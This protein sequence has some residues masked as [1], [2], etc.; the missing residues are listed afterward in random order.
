MNVSS[1]LYLCLIVGTTVTAADWPMWRADAGRTASTTQAVPA[2]LAIL[3]SR[4]LGPLTPAYRETR[5]Q[6]DRS[7][8]PVVAGHT[9][10]VGSSRDDSVTAFDTETGS[11]LWKTFTDGPIRFAPVIVDDRVIFGSDD[12]IVRCVSLSTGKQIWDR[13]AVPSNRHVLGNG[14]LISVW[15]VRGGPVAKGGRVYL[16]AGVWPLEG[17]FVYCLDAR[18][19]D[20]IW[21]NDRTGYIY[22]VHPHQAEAFGGVAPQGYLLI[23]GE[24]LVVPSSSAYPARFDLATGT[25]KEFELPSAGRLPGG[26]FASTPDAKQAQKL[27]RRGLLFDDAVNNTRHEDKPRKEGLPDIRTS[28]HTAERDLAFAGPWPDISGT[29][30]SVVVAAEK[31]FVVTEEGR[32]YALAPKSAVTQTPKT[33]NRP[34]PRAAA[35]DHDIASLIKTAGTDRG[36]ALIIGSGPE[37]FIES[38]ADQTH[39][40]I[41]TL[42]PDSTA[43]TQYRQR[44]I[45]IGLYGDRISAFTLES[46]IHGL[47]PYFAN[48]ILIAPGTETPDKATLASLY[49]CLRP[50][51]GKIIGPEALLTAAKDAAL[52]QVELT[53]DSAKHTIIT[54]TGALTGSTNYTGDWSASDDLLVKSPVGILWFDDS[55]GNF[56]RAPQPQFIDGVMVTQNKDWMDASTRKGPVDYR[57]LAPVFS[58]VYTG[59]VL[60]EYEA[61][62]LRDQFADADLKTIQPNQYRPPHQKDDWK[63][64][65]PNPGTRINPMTL[66]T[67]PRVFPKS[68]G[69]DGGFD[70]GSIYTMRSGTAAF[71]DKRVESGTIHISGPRSGCTNSIVPA[72]G[73]LN[74]PYFFEGCTCSYPLP[75]AV[76]LVSLPETFEQW[77]AWGETPASSLSGKIQRLG[78]NFG[79]P[80]DRKTEDGTLWLD[81]P[82][83]GG[84]S[85]EIDVQ[86]DPPDAKTYYHHSV[87]IEG[88]EGWPWVA[89]SGIEGASTIKVSGLKQGSYTVRLHFAEPKASATRAL[90]LTLQKQVVVDHFNILTE[91]GGPLRALTKTFKNISSADGTLTVG[92]EATKGQTLI[93]G[94]EISHEGL[95]IPR[96]QTP[97][98]V[99]SRIRQEISAD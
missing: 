32:L 14:R 89:A 69:C 29:V 10:I 78:I 42:I 47:P 3:W 11:Q 34:T 24:D 25:L 95:P 90:R 36:Y 97:A 35:G 51:G 38:L 30:G 66:E 88:G 46:I 1:L 54:R 58:D 52:P 81:Y 8:E 98:V 72:N 93:C 49:S 85:P 9:L 62:A 28:I 37:G 53:S 82:S 43:L 84:P 79:A 64:G 5:L 76:S 80:G 73:V 4:D 70:Y 40:K 12:G 71:Y 13:R 74:V 83:V 59:R 41:T 2:D 45:D 27:K 19:G 21:L 18:T 17:V 60:D 56:K 61:P 75:M 50:Y 39:F 86:I 68:Y 20:V 16:A 33:W 7:H 6:F 92:L 26:W 91:A 87:W 48:L 77:T 94:I 63:P 31:C 65:K 23:D 67:E 57:L 55:L 44:M 15:P 96:P 22:G 99:P